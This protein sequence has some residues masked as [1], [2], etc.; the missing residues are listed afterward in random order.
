MPAGGSGFRHANGHGARARATDERRCVRRSD[1]R[2]RSAPR[3]GGPEH[4]VA[5]HIADRTS[6]AHHRR[7]S[8]AGGR[9]DLAGGA[10]GRVAGGATRSV[11]CGFPAPGRVAG[12]TPGPVADRC[13]PPRG[14]LSS[15]APA[16]DATAGAPGAGGE[17][18]GW[19]GPRR[20]RARRRLAEFGSLTGMSVPVASRGP[21]CQLAVPALAMRTATAPARERPTSAAPGGAATA[22]AA[23][24]A[25]PAVPI[26]PW[27]PT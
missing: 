2:C 24:L 22:A 19:S 20:D 15:R 26:T 21:A 4:A 12:A 11:L 10:A 3:S 17:V 13:G 9:V 5:P 16:V 27:R 8:R 1:R 7:A 6:G 25:A 14:R 23:R 18:V